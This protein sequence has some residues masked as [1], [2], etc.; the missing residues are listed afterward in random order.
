[1]YNSLVCIASGS[2]YYS[3]YLLKVGIYFMHFRRI[4][5]FVNFQ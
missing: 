2:T 3:K 4:S 5:M 1:M